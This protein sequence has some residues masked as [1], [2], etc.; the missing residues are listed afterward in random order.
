MSESQSFA[1]VNR[2]FRELNPIQFGHEYCLSS[3][4]YGPATRFFYLI[5]YVVSGEGIFQRGGK[6]Y[7]LHAGQCFVIRP[8]ET[9]YY[10]ADAQNP[11]HYVWIGFTTSLAIPS[12]MSAPV[13]ESETASRI[14]LEMLQRMEEGVDQPELYLT[15]RLWALYA[16]FACRD[17]EITKIGSAKT[18]MLR[19]KNAIETEYMQPVTVESLAKRLHLERSYF[20]SLFKRQFGVSP[21]KYLV[22]YRLG[23]AARLLLRERYTPSEAAH[24]VGYFDLCNFSRMFRKKYGTSPSEYAEKERR[25]AEE[26]A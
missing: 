24:A 21:Q 2:N 3:H 13:L 9:T 10:R 14:F 15:A 20:S 7:H 18:M 22:E 8:D 19:A 1:L 16:H 23:I 26:K 12:R 11:W 4:A 6:E 25:A 5:H 17:E